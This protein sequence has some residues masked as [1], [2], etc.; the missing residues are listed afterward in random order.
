[1]YNDRNGLKDKYYYNLYSGFIKPY[2]DQNS[3]SQTFWI[4]QIP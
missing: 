4:S 1:M 3:Y 2:K